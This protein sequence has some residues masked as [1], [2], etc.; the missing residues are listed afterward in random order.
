MTPE[1]LQELRVQ[2]PAFA[3]AGP[4]SELQKAFG[5]F[6]GIDF[7]ASRPELDYR[8]GTVPSGDYSLAVHC[9]LQP[10]A[11]SN[12]LLVHGYFDHSGLFGKLIGYGL[13]HNCNVMIFDLPG[14]GLSSGEVA[15]ID[16]FA[17]YG[18]AIAAVLAAPGLP[19]DL[20]LWVMAQSTGCSALVELARQQQWP[21]TAAVLLAPLLRPKGWRRGKVAHSLLR[22]FV[23]SIERKFAPN[24]SDPDFLSFLCQ[25]PLQ[26]RRLSLRWMSALRRW[27]AGL[28]RSDLGAGPV[29]IVQGD[30][31]QTVD[32]RYNLGVYKTLF[33]GSQ[34]TMLPGAG[35]QLANESTLI[36]QTYLET[37]G[38]YLCNRGLFVATADP[39]A[40]PEPQPETN[41]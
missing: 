30:A 28:P 24:S 37:V 13:A 26:S 39:A 41:R 3:D 15:A 36:R 19:P 18:R 23:D 9:W 29:L 1:Q 31:D 27:I 5:R 14:H 10:G 11:T 2:L 21:F 17:D 22:H 12:L 20:P 7:A 35:H 40:R 8:L 16:D 38:H 33:P 6:Y 4:G 34:V 25:D 32:W